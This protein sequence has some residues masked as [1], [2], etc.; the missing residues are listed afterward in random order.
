V[1]L[2]GEILT[3]Y[4]V[5][6]WY[7]APEIMLACKKYSKEVDVWAVGCIFGEM[8]R[9]KAMFPG[10]DYMEQL[11]LIVEC[12]GTPSEDDLTFITSER[13]LSFIRKQRGNPASSFETLYGRFDPLAQDLLRKML[14][15]NPS[16]R[17][18]IDAALEHPYLASL[19]CADDEPVAE[20]LFN[21]DWEKG[22]LDEATLQHLMFEEAADYHPEMRASVASTEASFPDT[23]DVPMTRK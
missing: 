11:R 20:S 13:A 14:V 6:R 16:R 9:R 1:D 15:L 21:F 8:L 7:R 4:V 19:H 17:L 22:A 10:T 5:T 23:P 2:S 12:M 3:E 18:T